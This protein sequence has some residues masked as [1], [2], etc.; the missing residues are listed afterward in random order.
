MALVAIALTSPA[1]GSAKP[2]IKPHPDRANK[3]KGPLHGDGCFLG[4]GE[5]RPP[6]CI[7]GVR[8]SNRRVVLFGD[9]HAAHYFPALRPL[10]RERG[11]RLA[12]F[13]KAGC[14]PMPIVKRNV[15]GRRDCRVWRQRALRR[16]EAQRPDMVIFGST[17]NYK[18]RARSG[19][20]LDEEARQAR[21]EQSYTK[22]LRRIQRT[23]A[24]TVVMRDVPKAP[25][26]VPRCVGENLDDVRACDFPLPAGH[27]RNFDARAARTT[28]SRLVSVTDQICGARVCRSVVKR[29]LVY[30]TGSHLTAPFARL[31]RDPLA[32]RLPR[33]R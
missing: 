25:F 29:R 14:G 28:G 12:V 17:V 31:L 5:Y 13:G 8:D 16:I 32:R 27:F 7:Y 10:L 30:R 2:A 33:V 23:G 1:A 20:R 15:A 9:S 22:V 19:E 6:R 3:A 11:W 24:R 26:H 21:L 4:H 18:L